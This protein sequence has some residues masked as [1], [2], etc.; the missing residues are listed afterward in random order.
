VWR[1]AGLCPKKGVFLLGALGWLGCESSR[2]G[3]PDAVRLAPSVPTSPAGASPPPDAGSGPRRLYLPETPAQILPGQSPFDLSRPPPERLPQA[4]CPADMVDVRGAFCVDRYEAHLIDRQSGKV[5]SPYYP[6]EPALALSSFMTWR[7]HTR[8]ALEPGRPTLELPPLADWQRTSRV[9]V[10]AVSEA[11]RVPSGYVDGHT[12]SSA[13]ASAGKR[14]CTER[15]WQIACR[16]EADQDFPYGPRY[17]ASACNVFRSTHPA[18]VLHGNASVGHLD[19]RLNLVRDREGPLLRRTG[20]SERCR[21]VWGA[22]AIYDMVGNLD[23]WVDDP[24]GAF[25]GGFYARATKLGCAARITSHP[26]GYRD[27]SLGVRCCRDP[28]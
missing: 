25:Q 8:D 27:Y 13:C 23:E 17:E 15:E 21:S 9:D 26:R 5:L 4:G 2:E 7:A 11:G 14:L 1:P 16:G 28:G 6:P 22:D 3:P 19:P 20:E 18:I 10:L 24:G 12:A